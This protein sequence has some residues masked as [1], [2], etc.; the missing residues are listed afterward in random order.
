MED[1]I[2]EVEDLLK[3]YGYDESVHQIS[4]LL[5]KQ[6]EEHGDADFAAEYIA[7][8]LELGEYGQQK[9]S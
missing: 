5:I 8:Q 9:E 4:D 2:Y 1:F 7:E 6:Y 3:E